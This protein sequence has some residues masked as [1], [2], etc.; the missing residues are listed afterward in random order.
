MTHS[1]L[2]KSNL[3][4]PF[5][6]VGSAELRSKR[7]SAQ[8]CSPFDK[9]R[10][11]TLFP[12]S[13]REP[14][15]RPATI[16]RLECLLSAVSA[17]SAGGLIASGS[18]SDQVTMGRERLVCSRQFNSRRGAEPRR[19]MPQASVP[20]GE[21]CDK[22]LA[23]LWLRPSAAVGNVRRPARVRLQT[24]QWPEGIGNSL[25]PYQPRLIARPKIII[26]RARA[27]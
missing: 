9:P 12:P 25:K 3:T 18:T 10:I 17:S 13:D 1:G 7:P 20:I 4:V 5:I 24:F 14:A 2:G 11:C 23:R 21:I 26:A 16:I 8:R 27:F 19:K 22:N 15:E 6:M